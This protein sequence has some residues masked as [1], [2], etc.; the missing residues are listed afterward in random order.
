MEA[1]QLAFFGAIAVAGFRSNLWWA[2]GGIA[3]HGVFD[4]FHGYLITNPGMPP[5][6]PAFCSTIDIVLG[7]IV[8]FLLSRRLIAPR[9]TEGV[10]SA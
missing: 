7:A 5:W 2:A 6:W 1:I 4:L 3:G 9:A 10:V 8:A